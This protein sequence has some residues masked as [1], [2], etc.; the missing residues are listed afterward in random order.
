MCSISGQTD[1]LLRIKTVHLPS[2]C[3]NMFEETDWQRFH[4]WTVVIL[5]NQGGI[6]SSITIGVFY[7]P[8]FDIIFHHSLGQ[9]YFNK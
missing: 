6:V 2:R 4:L 5:I 7:V 1:I 3:F 8:R 9:S